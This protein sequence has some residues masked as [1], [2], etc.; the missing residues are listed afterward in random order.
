MTKAP[1]GLTLIQFA[2]TSGRRHQVK[3]NIQASYLISRVLFC[4]TRRSIKLYSKRTK[5]VSK[6]SRKAQQLPAQILMDLCTIRNFKSGTALKIPHLKSPAAGI[7]S[8]PHSRQM[9][10]KDFKSP[11][12]AHATIAQ[13]LHML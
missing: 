12:N 11:S 5:Q 10:N 6:F 1:S 9:R 4:R 3:A 13:T 7:R 8:K 2:S